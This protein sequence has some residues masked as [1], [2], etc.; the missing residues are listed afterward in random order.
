VALSSMFIIFSLAS[1][2]VFQVLRS[3]FFKVRSTFLLRSLAP[4][5]TALHR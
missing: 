3:S 1:V 5:H 2:A 4:G